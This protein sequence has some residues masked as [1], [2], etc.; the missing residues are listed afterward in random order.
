VVLVLGLLASCLF[1]AIAFSGLLIGGSDPY[2]DAAHWGGALMCIYGLAAGLAVVPLA[3]ILAFLLYVL[4]E[5]VSRL[6]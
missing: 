3:L 1:L 2:G 5:L 6:F 4:G